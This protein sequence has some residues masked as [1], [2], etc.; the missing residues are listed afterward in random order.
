M[1]VR[2][3]QPRELF[4]PP[5]RWEELRTCWE[6]NAEVFD[7]VEV[8]AGR[9]TF[10]EMFAMCKP[11]C[12]NVIANSDIYFDA[13]GVDLMRAQFEPANGPT[14][15]F[16]LSRW[17]VDADGNATHYNHADSQDAWVIYGGPR[18]IDAP[19]T[20]GVP[21]CDNSL[22]HIL[23]ESGFT[24]TNPSLSIKAYHLHNVR[25]RSYLHDPEGQARGGVK[26]YRI[27]P[28]YKLVKPT[29]L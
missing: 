15:V 26:P 2:L 23:A 21:G 11:G 19:F 27:P 12:L 17:D 14:K 3:I 22:A 4:G 16:A 13:D 10:T 7:E 6:R 20:M 9:A 5:E 29:A 28:P 24:V 1:N 18:N 25:W 8:A